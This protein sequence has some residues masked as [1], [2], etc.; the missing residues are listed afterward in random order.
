MFYLHQIQS[1]TL[2]SQKKLKIM[3]KLIFLILSVKEIPLV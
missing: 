1:S 3:V 2:Y